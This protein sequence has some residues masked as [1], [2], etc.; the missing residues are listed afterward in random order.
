MKMGET[1]SVGLPDPA[2]LLSLSTLTDTVTINGRA[3]TMSYDGAAQTFTNTTPVGRQST[4]QIDSLGRIIQNQLSGLDALQYSYDA[5]GR[6]VGAT[7]GSGAGARSFT[8]QYNPQGYLAGITDPLSNVYGFEYDQAGRL[9]QETLADG[10]RIAYSYDSNG[11]L[12]SVTPPGRPAHS[13]AYNAVDLM[14]EYDPPDVGLASDTTQYTYNADRQITQI[15]KPDGQTIAF[16]Y[17]A[18]SWL[19]AITSSDGVTSYTYDPV[20]GY[21]NGINK[22]GGNTLSYTDDGVLALGE[23]WGGEVSGSV[24]MAYD[25]SFRVTGVSINGG[26]TVSYQYDND[27]LITKAGDLAVTR[28]PQNGFLTG[29]SLGA[30]SDEW[31][32]NGFGEPAS[33]V[34][35]YGSGEIFKQELTYDKLGRITMK[36]ETLGGVTD[37]Y[38]Y[39]Y[40]INGKLTGVKKNG[41]VTASY[42]YDSNDNRLSGPIGT[43]TYTYDSQDRLVTRSS[44]LGTYSYEYTANGEL[45]SKATGAQTVHYDYDSIGNLKKVTLADGTVIDYVADGSNRRVGKKVNGTWARKLLY[46]DELRPIA[47][48]D[49]SNNV[50]SAF[51]YGGTATTPQYMVKGGATYRIVKDYLGSPRLVVNVAD[52]TIVQRMD[53]DEFGKVI[54]DTNPGFQPFGFAGG[55]YDPQTGLVRFGERDYDPEVGRWTTKDPLGLAAGVNVYAYVYGDPI[56]LV[57]PTGQG[58]GLWY[59]R[60]GDM[61]AGIGDALTT[62]PFTGWSL[63]EWMRKR[64]NLEDA[65]DPCSTQYKGGKFMGTA[66]M[67][68]RGGYSLYNWAKAPLYPSRMSPLGRMIGNYEMER[69]A[70]GIARD[71]PAPAS[72]PSLIPQPTGLPAPASIT[73]PNLNGNTVSFGNW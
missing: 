28:S 19:S 65:V 34:A 39:E 16:S 17:D 10:S 47:E 69:T 20:K 37:T 60:L 53:Y 29:T 66:A 24:S 40:E 5:R 61:L 1:R 9:T 23:A 43:T 64:L 21:L 55:V 51:V 2:N 14:V 48:L 6:L 42:S 11:N 57:D 70:A 73:T 58:S 33:Y 71:L 46:L 36:A 30:V 52:G 56:N 22:P 41:A 45:K 38:E 54:Q 50:S 27:S 25:S 35:R 31:G 15:L 4:A 68:A 59:Y 72:L 67:L 26:S 13:F 12:T 63:S 44:G 8:F 49:A 62:V 3:Y 18:G 32:Y 7:Q